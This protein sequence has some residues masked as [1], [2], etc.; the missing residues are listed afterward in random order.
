MS[1]KQLITAPL[2][3]DVINQDGSYTKNM[4]AFIANCQSN[5][6]VKF[7]QVWF[8]SNDDKIK[9]LLTFSD[10]IEVVFDI[11]GF[12]STFVPFEVA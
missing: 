3:Y 7:L 4:I 12:V 10:P 8:D 1:T 2:M 11:G 6:E 9:Y 5:V